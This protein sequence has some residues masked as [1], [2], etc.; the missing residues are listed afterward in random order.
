M[1]L[2]NEV[3]NLEWDPGLVTKMQIWGP[4]LSVIVKTQT[5]CMLSKHVGLAIPVPRRP[6]QCPPL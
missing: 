4:G 5:V 3:L 2:L 6:E 1:S